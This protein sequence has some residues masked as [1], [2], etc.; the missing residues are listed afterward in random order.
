MKPNVV[1]VIALV[2]LTATAAYADP[3]TCRRWQNQL[4]ACEA[5]GLP[6]N[7][8]TPVGIQKELVNQKLNA[9]NAV[10]ACKQ[11]VQ[12]MNPAPYQYT[13]SKTIKACTWSSNA[14]DLT[15][16]PI[17]ENPF[18]PPD[19]GQVAWC[20]YDSNNDGQIN[21][22][23]ASQLGLTVFYGTRTPD[24]HCFC[25]A[26]GPYDGLTWA[27]E[28][29]SQWSIAIAWLRHT[30]P[31]GL[32]TAVLAKNFMTNGGSYKSD[33]ILKNSTVSFDPEPNLQKDNIYDADAAEIDHIIPR[34]D[35][36]G[37]LCGDVTPNN[38]AVISRQL[39][40]SMSNTSPA[41]N[42]DR[43]KMY[44]KYV[45]CPNSAAGKYQGLQYRGP[46]TIPVEH[47]QTDESTT[48]LEW[49]VPPRSVAREVVDDSEIGGCSAG[50]GLMG[51]GLGFALLGLRRRRVT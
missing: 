40:A 17:W 12:N 38:A 45:T 29:E 32:K 10:K 16:H 6:A 34:V 30:F 20:V 51:I 43:A 8:A 23:D 4:T 28:L 31:K 11:L 15:C 36:Q 46:V 3:P 44:A 1:L 49:P 25:A 27:P 47:V 24:P 7:C 35:S 42:E 48:D 18:N 37:C 13:S 2:A 22:N 39:N 9:S 33:A 50:G 26:K 19:D 14:S 41:Y 21:W 5:L